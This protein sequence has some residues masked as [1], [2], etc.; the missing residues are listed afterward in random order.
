MLAYGGGTYDRMMLLL[1]L[2]L[3]TEDDGKHVL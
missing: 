1:L 2:S 3:F